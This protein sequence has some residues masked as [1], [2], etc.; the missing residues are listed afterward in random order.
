M[1]RA[2]DR[3]SEPDPRLR[4]PRLDRCWLARLRLTRQRCLEI[5]EPAP[6]PRA[7][8]T[9]GASPGYQGGQRSWSRQ[10]RSWV[11]EEPAQSQGRRAGSCDEE[12]DRAQSRDRW[13]RC[14]SG[15]RQTVPYDTERHILRGGHHPRTLLRSRARMFDHLDGERL[16]R[17]C[18]GSS[19]V[20]DE[21]EAGRGGER[22]SSHARR[23]LTGIRRLSGVNACPSPH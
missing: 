10:P 22:P 13:R 4:Q 7:P 11:V 18:P 23:H 16:W 17:G 3:S 14:R 19:V 1:P 9:C 21:R 5:R 8:R 6:Q 12:V 2:G 15:G 20:I